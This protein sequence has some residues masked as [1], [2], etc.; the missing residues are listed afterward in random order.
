MFKCIATVVV[1]K[2]GDPLDRNLCL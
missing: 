2:Q 1:V